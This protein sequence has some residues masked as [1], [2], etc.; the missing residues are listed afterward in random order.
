[1]SSEALVVRA[2]SQGLKVVG[3]TDHD[4]TAGVDDAVACGRIHG[5]TVVPGVEI[6]AVAEREEIH[7][8]GYFV[9]RENSDLQAMLTR[10]RDARRERAREMLARLA[11]LGLCLDWE[12][13]LE[14][15]GEGSAIGRPHVA[16]ALLEAGHIERWEEAFERWIGRDCPAY[17]ERYK[18]SPEEAI[19]LVRHSGGLAVVAHP[20]IYSRQG[21]RRHGLNLKSWLPRLCEAGLAGIEVYYPNYPREAS[22]HLLS[23]AIKHRLVITG[24]S[25]FHGGNAGSS[26][27]SVYVPWVA[28]QGLLRRY[29]HAIRQRSQLVE[30]QVLAA[31]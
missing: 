31:D 3:I 8:L 24:G 2:A 17:V 1:M 29:Q 18:L 30:V 9:D 20:Y 14:A 15:A 22:R 16:M 6:S 12:G 26:L 25:D 7:L 23:L 21:E 4:T 19:A 13:V 10:T 5:V 11:R 28:W 27:G